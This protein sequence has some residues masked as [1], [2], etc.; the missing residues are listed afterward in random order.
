MI[1]RLIMIGLDRRAMR[2]RGG[3]LPDADAI[4]EAS[5]PLI[6]ADPRAGIVVLSTCER[7]EI[8]ASA[9][10]R[11]ERPLLD[12]IDP[13]RSAPDLRILRGLSVARHLLRVA[14]GLDSRLIGE[15]HVLGQVRRAAH[16]ARTNGTI[17][18][19]PDRL[20]T[21]ALRC[22][23]RVRNETTLGR[24]GATY[25]T[26]AAAQAIEHLAN[27]E[28]P[29]VGIIGTGAIA[30]EVGEALA[31]HA[32]VRTVVLGRHP[33]RTGN[34]ASHL[35]AE[36]AHLDDLAGVIPILDAL[37]TATAAPRPIVHA[38]HLAGAQ[39]GFLLIDLSMPPNVASDARALP[40]ILSLG[41]DDVAPDHCPA[42]AVVRE[43][44]AIVEQEL[45]K[46]A[47]PSRPAGPPRRFVRPSR[48][49]RA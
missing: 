21:L 11:R 7:F 22:G 44:E 6:D 38:S 10:P 2:A 30:L 12:M 28:G 16:A 27:L 29:R 34:L 47:H 41:L 20:F 15:T 32:P 45:A 39:P 17:G 36:A 42:S 48:G 5:R 8:Y 18:A 33:N 25:A 19:D 9:A 13:V 46:L 3:V 4:V 1:E 31:R 23:K 26:L 40:A 14:A 43:A 37:I 49:V 35:G 24:T